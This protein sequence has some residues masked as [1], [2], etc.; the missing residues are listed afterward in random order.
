M[1]TMLAK[2]IK[3]P[4]TEYRPSPPLFSDSNGGN[5]DGGNVNNC[6]RHRYCIFAKKF[7]FSVAVSLFFLSP[8]VV[9][10]V[11]AK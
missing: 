1:A 5:G 9:Y 11:G 3:I 8:F 7:T 6:G 4:R 2:I 10:S